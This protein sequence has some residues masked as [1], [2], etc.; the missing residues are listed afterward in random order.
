MGY[1][2]KNEDTHRSDGMHDHAAE[3]NCWITEHS[4]FKKTGHYILKEM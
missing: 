2:S 4:K 3:K 1:I